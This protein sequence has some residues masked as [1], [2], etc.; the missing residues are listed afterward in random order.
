MTLTGLWS[1]LLAHAGLAAFTLIA[2]VLF[3][4]LLYRIVHPEGG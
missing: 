3:A 1:T 2:T 4:Y